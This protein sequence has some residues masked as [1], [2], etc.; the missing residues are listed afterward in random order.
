M[1]RFLLAFAACA[2][3]A[4]QAAAHTAWLVPDPAAPN[5]WRLR[6]GGHEG[7]L[8]PAVPAKLKTLE[9]W[10]ATGR[11]LTVNRT[12]DADGVKVAVSAAPSLIA[13][14]YDNGVH[15]RTAAAGP[16]IERPMNEVPGAISA[17][18]ALKYGKAIAAWSPTVTRVVGQR[19]EVVPLDAAQPQAGRP[20][21]VRVL[22]DGVPAQGVRLGH[23]EEGEA[24]VTDADGVASFVPVVGA[25]KLW[26]GKRFPVTDDPRF[27]QLSYEYLMTFDA[28]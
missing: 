20:M 27:T 7:K 23:G 8:V 6:F 16:S 2:A 11:E 18:N 14:H 5:A 15:A 28:R 17:V 10:D 21:R 26:A 19:M 9:A 3:V 24:G 1:K 4:G 13:L 12:E 25:N 22:I